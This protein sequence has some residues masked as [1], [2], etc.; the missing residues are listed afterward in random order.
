MPSICLYWSVM[1]QPSR[2][3]KV[4][5]LDSGIAHT[6]RHLDLQ[7]QEHKSPE[8][9]AI[10]P[11]GTVPF[12]TFD[13]ECMVETVA[14]MR[15]LSEVCGGKAGKLYSTEAFKQY[16][17]DKWCDFYTDSFRPAFLQHLAVF[18]EKGDGPCS[19]KHRLMFERSAER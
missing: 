14:V 9:C 3:L 2:A 15:F 10:N 12:I 16:Q 1:S 17:I 7:K 13:G 6:E 18:F 4:F 19:E 8:I 5:L 11:A